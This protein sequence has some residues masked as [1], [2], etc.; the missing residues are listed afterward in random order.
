M[1]GIGV[2]CF[3]CRPGRSIVKIRPIYTERLLGAATKKT[4]KTLFLVLRFL[5]RPLRSLCIFSTFSWSGQFCCVLVPST[6]AFRLLHTLI[7]CDCLVYPVSQSVTTL[8]EVVYISRMK[9]RH[10]HRVSWCRWVGNDPSSK[11]AN[12]RTKVFNREI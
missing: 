6:L 7:N 5:K 10:G 12:A 9:N 11:T 4:Y 8:K 3:L 2:G 1:E